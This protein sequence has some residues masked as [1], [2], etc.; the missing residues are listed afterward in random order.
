MPRL[1]WPRPAAVLDGGRER[2]TCREAHHGRV[3]LVNADPGASPE[4]GGVAT[5]RVPVVESELI[6]LIIGVQQLNSCS[7][8]FSQSGGRA[9]R[10]EAF[11][12]HA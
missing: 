4:G 3:A 5:G 10:S 7:D 6:G 2:S 8:L 12:P 1:N 11:S 9:K